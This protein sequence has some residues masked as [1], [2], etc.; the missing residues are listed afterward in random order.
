MQEREEVSV[1]FSINDA[2]SALRQ[3]VS[4]IGVITE[5]TLPEMSRGTDWF[6]SLKL[7]D[8]SYQDHGL[9]INVFAESVDKLPLV[10]SA[11][12]IVCFT[13]ITINFH[14]EKVIAVFK[15]S[16]STFALFE[17]KSS[18][19]FIPYQASS[20]Y[21]LGKLDIEVL[22]SLRTWLLNYQL[23][24]G[25]SESILPLEKIRDGKCFDLVCKILTVREVS[26]DNWMLFLW[27]G[28]D[29]PPLSCRTKLNLELE[30]PLPLQLEASL[31]PRDVLC[32]F[33]TVGTVLR[34]IVDQAS[35]KLVFQPWRW[36]K[37]IDLVCE[38]RF[39]LWCGHLKP[40]TR[41]RIL[42]DEDITVIDRQRI[43]ADR[44]PTKWD[45][46][47]SSA[48]PWPPQITETDLGHLPFAT[49]MDA[50][51]CSEVPTK[52]QCVVRVVA[53]C[54]W[55]VENFRS[56]TGTCVYRIRLTLEDPTAR[57]HA[58]IYAEDGEKFFNGYPPMDVLMS[59]RNALLGVAAEDGVEDLD[60]PRNPPW[61][62]L[63]LKSYFV[64]DNDP[65]SS[66][67]YRVFDTRLVA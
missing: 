40:S 20:S 19:S 65:W 3:K 31:L 43:Y 39:G 38:E 62:Q 21:N 61:V 41:V 42:S 60:A 6:C 11:G 49:L 47:P 53:I 23:D 15:K 57:I 26:K 66:R 50:L 10:R 63:C 59:K 32:E 44:L 45:R 22:T 13:S 46:M 55:Q 5:Y 12:D 34:V 27:D 28:T 37:I 48:L 35:E 14:H 16:I 29:A 8:A 17:G 1:Y 54:P 58:I 2:V 51:T 25:T 24:S 36:V 52:F 9:V 64:D 56:P 67:K 7:M 18:K 30:N 33:P 4:L